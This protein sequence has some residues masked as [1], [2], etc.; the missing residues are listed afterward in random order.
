MGLLDDVLQNK[1][2]LGQ[3][4]DLVAKNPQIVAAA[5]SL[6]STKDASVGGTGGLGS[7]IGAF[8][9]KG[10]GDVAASWI[11]NGQNQGIS[12][13]QVASV[14]G[15]DTLSQFASKAGIGLAEAAPALAAV[16]PALVDRMTPQG[17]VP[18]TNAIEGALGGLLSSLAR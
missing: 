16:L 9:G 11:G 7:L 3:V 18:E 15:N 8:Q 4:A 2:A 14:L 1:A 12:A 17:Q 13:D 6:L 5:L 10:L